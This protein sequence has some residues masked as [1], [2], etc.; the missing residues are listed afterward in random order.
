LSAGERAEVE[1]IM[2]RALKNRPRL[3][4]VGLKPAA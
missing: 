1:A 2:D 3:P 4:D